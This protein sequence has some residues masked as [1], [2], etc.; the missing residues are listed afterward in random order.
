MRKP[1][2]T[3]NLSTRPEHKGRVTGPL[4]AKSMTD[5]QLALAVNFLYAAIEG[6]GSVSADVP[7]RL[8]VAEIHGS[9][10]ITPHAREIMIGDDRATIGLGRF[11]GML[12]MSGGQHASFGTTNAGAGNLL[13]FDSKAALV[14]AINQLATHRCVASVSRLENPAVTK[15]ATQWLADI[16][17]AQ[18]V[19]R[20]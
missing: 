4:I 1:T 19:Q 15:S 7:F 14:A 13:S 2:R 11:M 17:A 16:A 9:V 12:E 8:D 20:G 3:A 6:Q 5:S 10:F 18:G